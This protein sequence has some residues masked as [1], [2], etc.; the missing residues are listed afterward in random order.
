L[1]V[2]K[3]ST[4][5]RAENLLEVREERETEIMTERKTGQKESQDKENGGRRE[6]RIRE[7][8][9]MVLIVVR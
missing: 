6:R 3:R 7:R 4:G 5:G 8:I 2:S 1:E 9:S